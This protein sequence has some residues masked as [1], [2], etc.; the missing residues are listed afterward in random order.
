MSGEP[1][2]DAKNI[3][4]LTD[5]LCGSSCASFHEELKNVAG[6]KAVVVGGRAQEGAMQTVGGSKGGEVIPM[7]AIS[8]ISAAILKMTKVANLTDVDTAAIEEVASADELL[9]RA[10]DQNSR[11]QLQ[12]QIRKGDSSGSPLQYIYEAADCRLWYTAKTLFEPQAAWAAAWTAF[13][14]NSKCIKGST[15]QSTSISGGYKPYGAGEV[16]GDME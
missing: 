8:Q 1:A 6:V 12:D 3:V 15:N 11:I 2:F 13:T 9:T 14:D 7:S 4:M 10:G 5:G 16:K